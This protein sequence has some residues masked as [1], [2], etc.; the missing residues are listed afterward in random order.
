MGH[1]P[2]IEV[3]ALVSSSQWIDI[4]RKRDWDAGKLRANPLSTKTQDM[5]RI[6]S[7]K[8]YITSYIFI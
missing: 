8:Y 7:P 5:G 4:S 2:Q 6:E 3:F 1:S